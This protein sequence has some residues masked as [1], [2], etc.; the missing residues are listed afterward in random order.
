MRRGSGA[1]AAGLLRHYVEHAEGVTQRRFTWLR[2]LASRLLREV[3]QGGSHGSP[4]R[5]AAKSQSVRRSWKKRSVGRVLGVL[6][7]SRGR[8]SMTA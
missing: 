2:E 8:G 3:R 6:K 5:D 4:G 7:K 1:A